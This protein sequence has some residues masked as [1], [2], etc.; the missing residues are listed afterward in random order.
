MSYKKYYPATHIVSSKFYPL[1]TIKTVRK[2][3]SKQFIYDVAHRMFCN[4][5][6][7]TPLLIYKYQSNRIGYDYYIERTESGWKDTVYTHPIKSSDNKITYVVDGL[8][9]AILE[10]HEIQPLLLH[11]AQQLDIMCRLLDI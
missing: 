8:A 6:L 10:E 5:P 7:D 9:D 1:P 2:N 4:Y 11:M 3:P